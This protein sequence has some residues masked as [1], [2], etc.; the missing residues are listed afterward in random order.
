MTDVKRL[1]EEVRPQILM[2]EKS[3]ADRLRQAAGSR[4]DAAMYERHAARLKAA[5]HLI[6]GAVVWRFGGDK[7]REWICE[8]PIH[9][10]TP[11]SVR[12]RRPK[13]YGDTP[14]RACENFDHLWAHGGE[15][16]DDEKD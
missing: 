13:A 8:L 1:E 9:Q 2:L 16:E 15:E 11:S 5:P 4:A 12:R 6:Y 7:G 14:E 10:G 3:A